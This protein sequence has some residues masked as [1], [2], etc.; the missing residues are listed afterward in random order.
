MPLLE[1]KNLKVYFPLKHGVFSRVGGWVKAVDDVTF[2][3]EPNETLGLVGESGCGKTTVGRTII[4]LTEP[5]SGS[6]RLEGEELTTL[7]GPALRARRRKLQ[8]I[9]QDPFGSLNPRMTIEE[10]IGEALEIHHLG[11]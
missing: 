11:E 10:I 6:V 8:M 3:I 7:P 9:F 5:T 4:R 1:V 2:E